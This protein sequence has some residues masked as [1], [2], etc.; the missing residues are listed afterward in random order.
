MVHALD[1]RRRVMHLHSL[2]VRALAEF[3]VEVAN[4]TDGT[5]TILRLLARYEEITPN[6]VRQVGGD[7]FPRRILML[8]PR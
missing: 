3:L 1:F 6:M 2:N 4:E 7:Q 8:V 5:S